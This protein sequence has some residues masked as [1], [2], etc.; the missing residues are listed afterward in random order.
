MTAATTAQATVRQIDNEVALYRTFAN[1]VDGNVCYAA[2]WPTSRHLLTA[3][4]CVEEDGTVKW[5]SVHGRRGTAKVIVSDKVGDLAHLVTDKPV[6]VLPL[7]LAKD[8]LM[9]EELVYRCPLP[10]TEAVCLGRFLTM[11]PG[12]N[13][14][15]AWFDGWG[16]PGCSGGALLNKKGEIVAIMVG[17]D[18]PAV[19]GYNGEAKLPSWLEVADDQREIWKLF[20]FAVHYRSALVVRVVAGGI[21]WPKE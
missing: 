21:A 5:V 15:K 1:G 17:S 10:G 2:V 7:R 8:V 13:G 18:V 12:R 6:G 4:H 3:N 20:W 11:I 19:Y 9:A 16:I 14:D